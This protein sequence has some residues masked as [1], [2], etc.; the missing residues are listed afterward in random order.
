MSIEVLLF[1]AFGGLAILFAV[2]MILSRNAVHS[3][4]FLIGNFG[5][6]AFMFL[7]L[8]APFISMVQ[9]AVYAGAIMV[10]FLFVIMLLGAEK[11]SDTTSRRFPWLTGAGTF[12]AIALLAALGLPLVGGFTLP[13]YEGAAPRIRF[14]NAAVD[15]VTL[16]PAPT[17]AAAP[18]AEAT[19][20]ADAA[21]EG[22]SEA[23]LPEVI[24]GLHLT[25]QITG[26][27]LAEPLVFDDVMFGEKTE[28][29][30]LPAGEYTLLLTRTDTGSPVARPQT[31]TLENGQVLTL[32][33]FGELNLNTSTLVELEIIQNSLEAPE[34]AEGRFLVFNGYT[35]DEPLVPLS[36]V[37]LGG[38]RV[39]DT[40]TVN[41]AEVIIDPILAEEILYGE[42]PVMGVYP[43]GT[44]TLAI[45][46]PTYTLTENEDGSEWRSLTGYNILHQ[47]NEFTVNADEENLLLIVKD[48][49]QPVSDDVTQQGLQPPPTFKF[50]S[51]VLRDLAID[52]NPTF[53]SPGGVGRLLFTTYLLPVNL[54]GLL[55]LVALIGVIVITRPFGEKQPR[56]GNVRRR[57]SRP[58]TSV[59]SQQTGSDVVVDTPKLPSGE[60]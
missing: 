31:V 17:S 32:T 11:T 41:G 16:I 59:I 25:L 55:L 52:T 58:L 21:P 13:A 38:N 49:L 50:R 54:V 4:L 42:A 5:C 23:A 2:G 34:N 39:L 26:G 19:A 1:I 36:L 45:V 18:A 40:R 8:N 35:S 43:K 10:L 28:F 47:Y 48:G 30:S 56:R 37:D 9:I 29:T 57:V 60:E 6:V 33:A 7:M 22:E 12:F 27:T 24:F 46:E 14:V 53:G 15:P 20:E 51:V 44:Y 3:A